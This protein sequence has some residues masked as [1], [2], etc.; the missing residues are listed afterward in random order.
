MKNVISDTVVSG[1]GWSVTGSVIAVDQLRPCATDLTADAAT[2]RANDPAPYQCRRFLQI[3][4]AVPPM[5]ALRFEAAVFAPLVGSYDARDGRVVPYQEGPN[6]EGT[7][8]RPQDGL[9]VGNFN[10]E[11]LGARE[12]EDCL[13]MN[14]YSPL[15]PNANAPT[16]VFIRGGGGD[17]NSNLS[18]YLQADGLGS[19]GGVVFMP[20]YRNG[21]LG[22][23]DENG[24]NISD[25]LV[26]W[27][28]VL[29]HGAEFGAN[30]SR[31][32]ISGSS[33]GA[34]SAQ[35]LCQRL[36][37]TTG[38][39]GGWIFS[40]GAARRIGV[41]GYLGYSSSTVFEGVKRSLMCEAPFTRDIS[42]TFETAQ[43]AIDA[44]GFDWA[45]KYAFPAD[46]INKAHTGANLWARSDAGVD[47][48][49]WEGIKAVTE[50]MIFQTVENEAN[51]LG[52]TQDTQTLGF[53][54]FRQNNLA[55]RFGQ[56]RLQAAAFWPLKAVAELDRFLYC[57]G[58]FNYQ[59]YRMSKNHAG[60]SA[61]VVWNYKSDGNGGDYAGHTSDA[62]YFTGN[63]DW[64]A[65]L[66][67][68]EVQLYYKDLW[69]QEACMNALLN[70]AENL[71]P[72]VRHSGASRGLF[73][74]EPALSI[75][76]TTGE[77][78]TVLGN[79][80]GNANSSPATATQYQFF[81]TYPSVCYAN[82]DPV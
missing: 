61:R 32:I 2:Y 70:F 21:A 75:P 19:M 54:R 25:L 6:E 46:M 8:G 56:S 38:F 49:P 82:T 10:S 24:H 55:N 1:S 16:M 15:V 12:S 58:T 62:S 40:G 65:G 31:I 81:G 67:G 34:E 22:A 64:Q 47:P 20:D 36:T 4:F 13:T 35:Y 27:Q 52:I 37:G 50:P 71:D 66:I 57:F 39:A 33:F 60:A 68:E 29:A 59:A 7:D 74:V 63:S 9:L 78:W 72:N 5:G 77:D 23:L 80:T 69:M 76:L 14:V 79:T 42:G 11:A 3:P 48:R 51:L 28:W 17:L 44:N 45:V 18:P 73:A 30:L 43:A 53:S 26:A 41:E